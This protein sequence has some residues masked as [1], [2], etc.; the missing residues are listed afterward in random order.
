MAYKTYDENRCFRDLNTGEV[1]TAKKITG[2]SFQYWKKQGGSSFEKFKSYRKEKSIFSGAKSKLFVNPQ[3]KAPTKFERLEK[4][5]C[6][7]NSVVSKSQSSNNRGN[8]STQNKNQSNMLGNI[9]MGPAN[10][11]EFKLTIAGGVAIRTSKGKYVSYS[12]EEDE[13]TD[14]T[15]FTV[16]FDGAFY[17]MPTVEVEEGDLICHEGRYGYVSEVKKKKLTFLDVETGEVKT[18]KPVNSP[19][20]LKFYTK[21]VSIFDMGGTSGNSGL[22]GDINPMMLMMMGGNNSGGGA[23]P[24]GGDMMQMMLMSQMFGGGSGSNPFGGLFGAGKKK[25]SKKGKTSSEDSE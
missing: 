11:S 9:E 7:S 16:D 2:A 13:I 6:A 1:F 17:K 22:F 12:T 19:F 4:G 14:V 24:F 25:A 8:S 3:T 23:S 10:G 5:Y 20:G 15:G 18:V 21:V